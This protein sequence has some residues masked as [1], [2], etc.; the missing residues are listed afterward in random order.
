MLSFVEGAHK[1]E[2]IPQSARQGLEF[3]ARRLWTTLTTGLPI[4]QLEQSTSAGNSL[5]SNGLVFPALSFHAE[6]LVKSPQLSEGQFRAQFDFGFVQGLKASTVVLEYWG[7]TREQ[8]RTVIHFGMPNTFEVDTHPASMPW[9]RIP[10]T[11]FDIKR[12]TGGPSGAN[13]KIEADMTDHP[14]YSFDHTV[15]HA[16]NGQENF[17]RSIFFK[18]QFRT[19]FCFQNRASRD[20]TAINATEWNVHY[21]MVVNYSQGGGLRTVTDKVLDHRFPR[22]GSPSLVGRTDVELLE[23]AKRGAPIVTSQTIQSRLSL[24]APDSGL[25]TE[26]TNPEFDP[27][28]WT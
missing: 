11:R 21:D 22:G 12:G 1:F 10:A 20:F 24:N 27:Q 8:G 13:L 2:V 6:C 23:M 7:R 25:T 4:D 5:F 15:R 19:V 17:L 26:D 16:H 3:G 18:R 14:L 9:T 28:F